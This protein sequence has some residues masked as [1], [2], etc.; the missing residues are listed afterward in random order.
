MVYNDVTELAALMGGNA[1]AI[2]R[3]DDFFRKPDGT[4]DFSAAK[5][6][7]YDPTNEPD[8][9]AP[10]I[11]N[12]LGAP[13]KTQ[14]TVRAEITA[15]WTNTTGGI[16][17]ND[18]AGTMS[19][20][21]VWSALGLYPS[22]PGRADLAVTSPLFPTAVVHLGNGREIRVNASPA[23]GTYIASMR[24]NGRPLRTPFVP[25]SV[26]GAGGRLDVTLA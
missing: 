7:R 24:L 25:A 20:W 11:Y 5:N 3:L 17:G 13:R 23:G 9:Q 12:S 16:P 2:Q 18:D 14:E 1:V 21:L 10:Y 19:A 15:L 8:I 22:V 26:V 4:F 6:T